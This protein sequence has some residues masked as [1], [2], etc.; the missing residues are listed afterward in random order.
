MTWKNFLNQGGDYTG[1]NNVVMP[2][3]EREVYGYARSKLL[4]NKNVIITGAAGGIG[5]ATVKVFAE[6]GANIWA[7]ARKTK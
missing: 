4:Y 6:N 2:Y 1:L 3:I 7:F 5:K